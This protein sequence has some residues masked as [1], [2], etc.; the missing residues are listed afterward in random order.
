MKYG[1]S[2][3]LWNSAKQQARDAMINKARHR[4]MI[5]Y[6]DLCK[7]I[8]AIC[9]KPNDYFLRH[10]LDEISKEEDEAGRGMLTALVVHKVG[11]MEPGRGFYEL[12]EKL[13]RQFTDPV[14]FWIEELH[15]VHACWSN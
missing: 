13:G 3:S 2:E 4:A 11:D 6:T 15:F 10:L 7:A 1:Y 9:I 8:T 12:A 14:K 5:T